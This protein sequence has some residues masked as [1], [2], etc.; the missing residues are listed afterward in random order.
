V[1]Y[2]PNYEGGYSTQGGYQPANTYRAP[3][4]VRRESTGTIIWH[5]ILVAI[6]VLV[7]FVGHIIGTVLILTD[8]LSTLEKIL[9]LA[10]FW[11]IPV[12]GPILYL[13]LG[14]KRNRL[15]PGLHD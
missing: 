13:W 5:L 7:P 11:F 1:S 6:T 10:V 14:Q 15:I 3:D 12:I 4:A 2:E 8:R 9:W